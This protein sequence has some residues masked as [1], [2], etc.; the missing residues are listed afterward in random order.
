MKITTKHKNSIFGV[1]VMLDNNGNELDSAEGVRLFQ[2]LHNLSAA[3]LAAICG[4]SKR[5]V[6]GWRG[7]R[8]PLVSAL[9][10]MADYKPKRGGKRAD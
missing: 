8:P 5:T 1:P 9:N 10:V 3:D 6:D 2:E 4:V 7:G